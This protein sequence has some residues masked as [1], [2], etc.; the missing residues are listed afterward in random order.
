MHNTI[1]V[2]ETLGA[3]QQSRESPSLT[4]RTDA[5]EEMTSQVALRSFK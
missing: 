3:R 2:S 5:K 1:L 4:E